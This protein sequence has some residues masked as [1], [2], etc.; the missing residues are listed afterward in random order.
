[1]KASSKIK[2]TTKHP[3]QILE[4]DRKGHIW[5]DGV[6]LTLELGV[7]PF[8]WSGQIVHECERALGGDR[9]VFRKSRGRQALWNA[10]MILDWW[11][12]RQVAA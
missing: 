12:Q 9:N 4:T 6:T 10:S 3:R 5:C 11:H 1:M 2:I 8:S 7:S